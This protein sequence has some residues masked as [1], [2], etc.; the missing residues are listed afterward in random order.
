MILNYKK[1]SLISLS[2]YL[3]QITT[4][5]HLQNK[6]NVGTAT[7][8][9]GSVKGS[10][11]H[12]GGFAKVLDTKI[13]ILKIKNPT[14]PNYDLDFKKLLQSR[15]DIKYSD[16]VITQLTEL[17]Q[18]NYFSGIS[19]KSTLGSFGKVQQ[20]ST[21]PEEALGAQSKVEYNIRHYLN[22]LTKFEY[23]LYN[24]YY[25]YFHF[26]K[27]NNNQYL[28]A[29]DKAT[30]LLKLAF[31][32]NGC[33]ISKPI[34]NVVYTT[35]KSESNTTTTQ[36]VSINNGGKPKIIINLFY[37]VNYSEYA[38]FKALTTSSIDKLNKI[39][40]KK[41]G[42][43]N[44]ASQSTELKLNTN[45]NTKKSIYLKYISEYL[46]KLF[47]CDVELNLVRLYLPYQ[48]SNI[49][50][51]YLNMGSFKKRF[52]YLASRLFKKAQI[53]K[54]IKNASRRI[55]LRQPN[56][57][58]RPACILNG[59]FGILG[60]EDTEITT[61]PFRVEYPSGISGIN[62]RLAGRTPTQKLIPRVAER[63]AQ[64]GNFSPLNSKMI[65]KSMC[66]GTSKKGAFNFKIRLSH[67]FR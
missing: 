18:F 6:P 67:I 27:S 1:S 59:P 13:D 60:G 36:T 8:P 16:L 47:N 44:V 40:F 7:L 48:D 34:F 9:L 12:R 19:S 10:Q 25:D 45:L 22:I 30:N 37:F 51:Q 17:L 31:L 55:K 38:P 28:F 14:L 29:M 4:A 52:V 39:F 11:P 50:A 65:D 56:G 26:N 20:D 32:A 62:I 15:T 21:T 33:L 58:I 2:K 63:R 41:G 46:N 57:K 54:N 24:S 61:R 35:I 23:K 64:R 42:D 43:S 49:L 66:I 53:F 3:K 5:P